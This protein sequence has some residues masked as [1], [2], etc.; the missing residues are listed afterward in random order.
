ML[1]REAPRGRH[2]VT[3][4]EHSLNLVRD[5]LEHTRKIAN[6]AN[7][8]L[9]Q[10][11]RRHTE[12]M[13]RSMSELTAA[14]AKQTELG[15]RLRTAEAELR[16][17]D[18]SSSSQPTDR[19]IERYDRSIGRHDQSI[20]RHDRSIESRTYG[21]NLAETKDDFRSRVDGLIKSKPTTASVGVIPE[22]GFSSA[23][24]FREK[25]ESMQKESS[26]DLSDHDRLMKEAGMFHEDCLLYTSPS[27]RDS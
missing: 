21:S 9:T 19:S 17:G 14:R 6:Q 11:S 25:V 13:Q 18:P 7:D 16:R 2:Q 22:R 3:Q 1:E 5:E 12:E 27:P 20:G 26:L 8:E 15:D 4:L 10:M 23:A 24:E